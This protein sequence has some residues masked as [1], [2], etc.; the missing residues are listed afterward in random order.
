MS[1]SG[2]SA[3]GARRLAA[4]VGVLY[5]VSHVTSVAAVPLLR[6]GVAAGGLRL[7]VAL[8][9]ILAGAVIATGT[10]L[11]ALVQRRAPM[12][13]YTFAALR[14]LEGAVIAVGTLPVLVLVAGP[15]LV[16]ESA[17]WAL[18]EAAFLVGQG[19]IISVNTVVLGALILRSGAV[20]RWI[21]WLAVVGGVLV[22]VGNV[23]QFVGVADRA[24]VGVA[25]LL[26][27][28]VFVFEISFALTLIVRGM[29]SEEFPRSLSTGS[30]EPAHV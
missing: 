10:G 1:V 19:L 12:L 21:G 26:A 11:V 29:R 20:A 30:Q 17:V 5:L 23:L 14:L 8:E 25:G 2:G 4:V 7:G 3:E 22:L 15:G 28:P 18:H 27:I 16:G 9:L 6:S 13:A 24:A